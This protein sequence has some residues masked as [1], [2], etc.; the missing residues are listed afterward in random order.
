MFVVIW[1]FIAL[2]PLTMTTFH[3]GPA[4]SPTTSPLYS[5]PLIGVGLEALTAVFW[6]ASFI[7]VAVYVSH[8]FGVGKLQ[9]N[10]MAVAKATAVFGAFEW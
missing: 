7:A 9:E 1:T 4:S 5:Y 2:I 10:S 6:F 8:S 3:I